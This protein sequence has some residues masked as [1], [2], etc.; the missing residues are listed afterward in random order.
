MFLFK[1]EFLP[2]PSEPNIKLLA[3][4]FNNVFTAKYIK[5]EM[6]LPLLKGTYWII[7]L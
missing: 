7:H 3:D 1:D 5:Y 4:N 6:I 2:L